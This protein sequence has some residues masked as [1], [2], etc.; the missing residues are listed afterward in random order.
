MRLTSRHSLMYK[1]ST[2]GTF[3]KEDIDEHKRWV[4]GMLNDRFDRSKDYQPT[5]HE[6]RVADLWVDATPKMIGDK[7]GVP[8]CMT[9][10]TYT[11]LQH[12][13]EGQG[14]FIISNSSLSEYRVMDIHRDA[15]GQSPPGQSP[16]G[17]G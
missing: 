5:G 2:D 1:R 3:T 13:S 12:I 4:W 6:Q 16:P 15:S 9:R 7:I 11:P 10:S 14:T 17:Y 8:S